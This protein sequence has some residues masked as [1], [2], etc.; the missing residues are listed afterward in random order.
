MNWRELGEFLKSNI[1]TIVIV[2][3]VAVAFP[4]TLIFIIPLAFVALP[5]A[6][7]LWRVRRNYQ[8]I[9]Q[10][11]NNANHGNRTQ[12]RSKDG[13]VTV[14]QTEPTEKRVNDDVGEYVDFKEIKE[15]NKQ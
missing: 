15:E 8:N 10:N 6:I 7:S 11:S 4:W 9:Y 2:T 3:V 5:I 1:L 14:V 12:S 13:K